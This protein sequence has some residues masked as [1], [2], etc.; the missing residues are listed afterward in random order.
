MSNL[1]N[2]FRFVCQNLFIFYLS[3]FIVAVIFVP[4]YFIIFFA[5]DVCPTVDFYG[6]CEQSFTQ[7]AIGSLVLLCQ[8]IAV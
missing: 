5:F 3:S 2:A 4:L 6:D 1:D 7:L 8:I